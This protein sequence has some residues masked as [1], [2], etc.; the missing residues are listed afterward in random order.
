MRKILF[1]TLL[2][3]IGLTIEATGAD[4][5]LYFESKEVLPPL[6]AYPEFARIF[7][8]E[9][10]F[11]AGS[12]TPYYCDMSSIVRSGNIV[13]AWI[14]V[15][16]IPKKYNSSQILIHPM[17][18]RIAGQGEKSIKTFI[19]AST[20]EEIL[21]Y[22]E[23]NCVERSYRKLNMRELDRDGNTVWGTVKLDSELK[24]IEPDSEM[25]KL[26]IFLCR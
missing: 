25:E 2:V 8:D 20:T 17:M 24:F 22:Y 23:I 14:K 19:S 13:R 6:S 4:W 12:R 16:M 21:Y 7:F 26:Y 15:V 1:I 5:K 10:R 9:S 3:T 18:D 11:Q